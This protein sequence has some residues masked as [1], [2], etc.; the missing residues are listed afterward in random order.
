[1]SKKAA[2]EMSMNT[3][4]TIV[5]VVIVMVL[6]IFFI[7]KIFQSGTNAIEGVD[8]EVQSQINKLF[9]S[10]DSVLSIYPTSKKVVFN[11]GD[12]DKGFA[13]SI[14]NDENEVGYFTY[15]VGIDSKFDIKKCGSAFTIATGNNWLAAP[16]GSFTLKAAGT[17]DSPKLV[18]LT[19]PKSS[20]AC[21]IP[22]N[23]EI[24]KKEKTGN[25][26]T[27]YAG[28]TVYIITKK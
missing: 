2:I 21:T 17:L 5:L 14:K 28:D 15:T 9:A 27:F 12:S 26:Y 8:N 22:Y 1:M 20:P 18:L 19:I 25:E 16:S 23:L 11:V 3:F 4:V 24:K 7:Q 13:F 10:G 6:G